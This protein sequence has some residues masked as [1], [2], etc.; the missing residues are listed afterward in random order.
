MDPLTTKVTAPTLD[1]SSP[2]KSATDAKAKPSKFDKLMQKGTSPQEDAAQSAQETS[3]AA[4]QLSRVSSNR[5]V[6]KLTNDFETTG[7]QLNQLK[8]RVNA[9]PKTPAMDAIQNR[10]RQ[11]DVDYQKLG[12]SISGVSGSASPQQLLKLQKDM[13]QMSEN[14]SAISQ[15]VSQ[16]TNSVK[17]ILQTQV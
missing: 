12:S 10:L 13:Y 3:Q 15:M 1:A 11:V 6:E 16:A 9:L 17:T 5:P 7:T 14:V 2:A 8:T 4:S